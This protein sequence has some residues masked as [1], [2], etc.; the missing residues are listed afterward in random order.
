MCCGDKNAIIELRSV[1]K[2]FDAVLKP[3]L[4]KTI[5]LE[6]SKFLRHERTPSV[7]ALERVGDCCESMYLDMMIIRDEG[8]RTLLRDREEAGRMMASKSAMRLATL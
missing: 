1:C 3:Y 2:A 8:M 5:Q 6:F 7:M 4:F